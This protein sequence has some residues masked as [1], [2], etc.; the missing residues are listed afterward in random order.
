MEI[1][2]IVIP[3]EKQYTHKTAG[4]WMRFCAYI[5][6]ALIIAAIIGVIIN[7]IF[8]L[9]D[10]SLADTV[11]YAPI[12]I[13]T[14]ITYYAY[15]VIMTKLWQQTLGK[16]IFGL[17]VEKLNGEKLDWLTVI[18]R[19]VVGRF[20]SNVVFYLPYIIIAFTT[21]N[22]GV[23]DYVADTVVVHENVF[24]EHISAADKTDI[25]YATTPSL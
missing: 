21:K 20:I 2:K 9:N 16:M 12:S 1:E 22:Q 13:I 8:L 19:E 14:T 4:F 15:F 18:F 23:Q 24:T 17:R 3:T 11:W 25:E 7:P 5:V 10:W 6:D